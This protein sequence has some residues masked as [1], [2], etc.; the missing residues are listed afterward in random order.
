MRS[1]FGALIED[2]DEVE[3]RCLFAFAHFIGNQFIAADHDG[4]TRAEV[5]EHALRWLEP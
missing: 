2:P 5:L 1:L 3:T 4:R